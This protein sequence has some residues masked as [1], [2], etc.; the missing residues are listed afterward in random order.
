MESTIKEQRRSR[1]SWYFYD[2]GNSAYASIILLAVF[3]VY[4]KNTI[5]PATIVDGIATGTDYTKNFDIIANSYV[6]N[7]EITQDDSN[8]KIHL[9][10]TIG[11]LQI[12]DRKQD[13]QQIS[14]FD[15]SGVKLL[16]TKHTTIDIS[17]FPSGMY[18]VRIATKNGI[19]TKK[20]VKY[21]D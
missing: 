1:W 3:S 10:P 16:N 13:I 15:L 19:L 6:G 20:I 11:T 5:V 4:F 14:I 12:E 18:V 8:I 9:N 2:F 21:D 7:I 17:H